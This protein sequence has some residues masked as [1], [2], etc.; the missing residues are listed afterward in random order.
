MTKPLISI[1]TVNYFSADLVDRLSKTLPKNKLYEFI[2]IDNSVD[3]EEVKKLQKIK[4]IN[5]LI[6]NKKNVGFGVANN[7]ASKKSNGE[8]LLFLNPDTEI[9]DMDISRAV[10]DFSNDTRLGILAPR[11]SNYNG[12]L[13]RSAHSKYPNWWSHALDYNP[14]LRIIIGKLG[15]NEYPT[16]FSVDSHGDVLITKSVLGAAMLIRKDTFDSINGFDQKFFLYREET[17]LCRRVNGL[18]YRVIFDPSYKI[19]HISGGASRNNNLAEFNHHYIKSS[20]LFISK[21]HNPVYYLLCWCLGLSGALISTII[22]GVL[23]VFNK[24][25]LNN[26]VRCLGGVLQHIKSIF[27]ARWYY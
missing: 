17:D 23:G 13:Q 3:T 7:I 24:K 27:G 18:G 16:L 6:I 11:I 21:W 14:A 15:L 4:K 25:H 19:K 8:L 10:A 12:S 1:I 20:Y 22:F 26:S 9:E 2:V 5:R